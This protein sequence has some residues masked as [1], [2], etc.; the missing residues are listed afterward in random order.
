MSPEPSCCECTECT[1]AIAR[2]CWPLWE[3]LMVSEAFAIQLWE[4]D[5]A[6]SNHAAPTN[7]Y[8]DLIGTPKGVSITSS[9][10]QS[11]HLGLARAA[12]AA[13]AA[14]LPRVSATARSRH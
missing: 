5:A 13:G 12:R 1:S 3:H 9:G 4:L 11:L 8:K 10:A 14:A 2:L 7:I 6:C